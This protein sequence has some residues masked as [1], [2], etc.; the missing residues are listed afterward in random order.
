MR[1]FRWCTLYTHPISAHMIWKV[2]LRILRLLG[3]WEGILVSHH[4][5]SRFW[6]RGNVALMPIYGGGGSNKNP[7]TSI[8]P[9]WN[10]H[11]HKRGS[12]FVRRCRVVW[13]FS[14]PLLFMDDGLVVCDVCWRAFMCIVDDIIVFFNNLF[15]RCFASKITDFVWPY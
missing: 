14:P 6:C 2:R 3:G 1:L 9:R 15:V 8:S 7:P 5:S 13:G 4:L 11:F 12:N 10:I